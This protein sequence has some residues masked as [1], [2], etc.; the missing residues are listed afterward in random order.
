ME[1]QVENEDFDEEEY[2]PSWLG[3]ALLSND[4]PWINAKTCTIQ[5]FLAVYTLHD[6]HWVNLFFD[7]ANNNEVTLVII[8]DAVWSPDEIAK[9]TTL[10]ND[11]PL[12]FIKLEVIRQVCTQGYETVTNVHRG[13][14]KTEIDEIDGKKVFVIHD[15]FCGSVEIV[16]EGAA[17]FLALNTKKE[18]LKI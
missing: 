12:L 7:V 16:F 6:S 9:S 15:H 11:W 1:D 10:V 8:W 18:L 4:L 5:E 14:A 17:H 2:Y 13:I 3:Q